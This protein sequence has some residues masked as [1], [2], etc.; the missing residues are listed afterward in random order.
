MSQILRIFLS[1]NRLLLTDRATC[2]S[3]ESSSY[4]TLDA[5]LRWRKCLESLS[6]T[7]SLRLVVWLFDLE[8]RHLRSC[9][10]RSSSNDNSYGYSQLLLQM[11]V[12]M[13]TTTATMV[14]FWPRHH[15]K[16]AFNSCCKC[17]F[18]LNRQFSAISKWPPLS[19]E[20]RSSQGADAQ[21]IL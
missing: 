8:V 2:Q 4:I 6:T 18:T 16:N 14:R 7:T 19:C 20:E 3:A 15:S 12:C 9:M 1:M 5:H 13:H 21:V 10:H 17:C 11:H